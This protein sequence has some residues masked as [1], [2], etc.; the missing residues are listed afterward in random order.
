VCQDYPALDLYVYDDG[1]DD[2]SREMVEREFERVVVRSEADRQG[3][4]ALRNRAY[5]ETGTTFIISIDDD[6]WLTDSR[7][8]SILVKQMEKDARIGALA[9]P[10]VEAKTT[11][12]P[13]DQASIASG[14][15]LKSFVGTAHIAR[16]DA[17]RNVGGYRSLFVHQGEE[18]DLCIRL[19]AAGW[20]VALAQ[21][22][23]IVHA[24]SPNRE[25]ERMHRYSVRNQVLVDFFYAPWPLLPAVVAAH[26]WRLSVHRTSVVWI[27]NTLRYLALGACDAWVHRKYRAPLSVKAYRDHMALPSHGPTYVDQSKLPPPC[28]APEAVRASS[29]V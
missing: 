23:P 17:V 3:Y 24:P 27:L 12:R 15:Q 18:R 28:S 14:A 25:H 13:A 6:A 20:K 29:D 21:A 11:P 5:L 19:R 2:G 26:A 22:P 10:Y 7:T 4:I 16:T 8:V 1:S 9:V